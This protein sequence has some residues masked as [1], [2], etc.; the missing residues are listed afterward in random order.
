LYAIGE[1]GA[2]AGLKFGY[3]RIS[4][5]KTMGDFVNTA[6]DERYIAGNWTNFNSTDAVTLIGRFRARLSGGAGY[7]WSI[8]NQKVINYPIFETDRLVFVPTV[9]SG[10]GAITSM[11]KTCSYKVYRE[12][13]E[14][15]ISINI[16]DKGTAAAS[17]IVTLP[18]LH[19]GILAGSGRENGVSGHMIICTVGVTSNIMY[20]SK[21]DST[22]PFATGAIFNAVATYPY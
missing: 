17:A 15:Y 14:C 18:L 19:Q 11:T 5:A 8:P 7:T 13:I 12:K 9:T 3:S 6:T 10:T 21:Y 4:H 16:V 20:L 22:T 2:S 1:T